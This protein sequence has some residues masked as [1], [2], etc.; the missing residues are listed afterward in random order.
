M[1]NNLKKTRSKRAQGHI[2][3]M[4]SFTI[5]VG[6]LLF[7]FIFL[8]PFAK[9]KSD[10]AINNVQE[11]I[12]NEISDEVGKLNIIV[13]QTSDCYDNTEVETYGN[14]FIEVQDSNLRKYTSYPLLIQ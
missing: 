2:E 5:F 13:N 10:Q 1:K 7:I 9:T 6:F 14:N 3:V 4:L 11:A 8:N 12:I